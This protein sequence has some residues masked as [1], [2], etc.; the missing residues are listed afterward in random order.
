MF[1]RNNNNNNNN[2]INA[3]TKIVQHTA[4]RT[5]MSMNNMC[6]QPNVIGQKLTTA[7]GTPI[8]KYMA[9]TNPSISSISQT[10]CITT[11][12][13]RTNENL[14]TNDQR[15]TTYRTIQPT[16]ARPSSVTKSV[17][18]INHSMNVNPESSHQSTKKNAEWNQL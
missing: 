6:V 2:T 15:V 4:P 1:F 8:A 10:P 11:A 3:N 17:T 14:Q 9:Q 18:V 12:Q 7:K 13:Y 5:I 16:E